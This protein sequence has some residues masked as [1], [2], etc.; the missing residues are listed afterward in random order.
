[1]H[2]TPPPC[3]RA[4]SSTIE[5]PSPEPPRLR[6]SSARLKRSKARARKSSGK[7]SPLV[8]DVQLDEAVPL[9]RRELDRPP[10]CASALSTRFTSACPTRSGSASSRRPVGSTRSSRPSDAARV[11]KRVAASSSRSAAGDR[12]SADRQRPLVG[13]GDQEQVV[14]EPREPLRLLG[15]RAERAL[16]LLARARPAQREVELRAQ[17]RERRPQLVARVGDEAALVLEGRVEAREHLVQRRR[18]PRDL[19]PRRRHRQPARLARRDRLRPAPQDLDRPQRAGRERVAAEGGGEQGEREEEE[20]LVAQVVERLGTWPERACDDGD[21]LPTSSGRARTRHSPGGCG[22]APVEP[23][24]CAG[25]AVAPPASARPPARRAAA[26]TRGWERRS[27]PSARRAARA[28]CRRR[29]PASTGPPSASSSPARSASG[30]R[31]ASSSFATR[32]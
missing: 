11:A 22:S 12:L 21:L 9:H 6:A 18:E 26:G 20:E 25:G 2:P 32:W 16:E 29:C 4:T 8:P 24:A 19:V 31:V 3:A 23:D 13:P 30:R 27:R 5:R 15:G 10:P 28:S 1:M 7:P 17:Q 14:G